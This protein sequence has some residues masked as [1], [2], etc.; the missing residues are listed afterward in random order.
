MVVP[1]DNWWSQ[2]GA[3]VSLASAS[4]GVGE[5]SG[6][7]ARSGQTLTDILKVDFLRGQNLIFQILRKKKW[8]NIT[9]NQL[10]CVK[11]EEKTVKTR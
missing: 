11:N 6:L 1:Y 8:K 4:S 3:P 9:K 5:M 7:I 10:I 2:N